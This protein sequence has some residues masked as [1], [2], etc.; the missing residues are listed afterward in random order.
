[1][2][3]AYKALLEEGQGGGDRYFDFDSTRI[4]PALL[5]PFSPESLV[6]PPHNRTAYILIEA[7]TGIP[8]SLE[9][10]DHT[11]GAAC[12]NCYLIKGG[13]NP[14]YRVPVETIVDMKN[15]LEAKEFNVVLTGADL[16]TRPDIFKAGLMNEKPY[17]LT[18][19][20]IVAMAPEKSLPLI[21]EAGIHNIQMSLHDPFDDGVNTFNGV[22]AQMVRK[23]IQNIREF[24]ERFK[25]HIGIVLNVTVGRHNLDRLEEIADIVLGNKD[26]GGLDCNGVRF[27]RH[28]AIGGAKSDLVLSDEDHILFYKIVDEIRKK[29]PKNS[30]Q[31]MVSVSGDFGSLHRPLKKNGQ[32]AYECPAGL[33]EGEITIVPQRDGKHMVF[34]CLEVRA[35]ELQM[36][37]LI[38]GVLTL[39]TKPFEE[40]KQPAVRQSLGIASNSG[41][42]CIARTLTVAAP[43]AKNVR[44]YLSQNINLEDPNITL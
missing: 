39:D 43:Y 6:R 9:K 15:T 13:V 22:P 23:A 19:G 14:N 1:M 38:N 30:T 42:G 32:P 28:K 29:Y 10:I 33:P 11:C 4:H 2:R 41:D 8:A 5:Q 12:N 25:T 44:Q 35:P 16:L 17:F 36:G 37:W 31:K 26:L 34:S 40:L 20:T 21:A 3:I 27:N 24:N 7:K 18:S